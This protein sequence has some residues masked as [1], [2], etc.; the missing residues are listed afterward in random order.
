MKIFIFAIIATILAFVQNSIMF[1]FGFKESAIFSFPLPFVGYFAAEIILFW[2]GAFVIRRFIKSRKE[3][4]FVVWS[5]IVLGIAELM[6]PASLFSTYVKYAQRKSVLNN[7]ELTGKSVEILAAEHKIG[8]RFALKYSLQFPKT[9]HYL[10]F[11]AYI[12]SNDRSRIFGNYFVKI[13]PEYYDENFIFEPGKSYEFTVVFDLGLKQFDA[14]NQNVCVQIYDEKGYFMAGR[15]L[16]VDVGD[17]LKNALASNPAPTAREPAVPADNFFDVAEKSIRLADLNIASPNIK[18]ETP[19]EFAFAI[20]NIGDKDI[21]LPGE[22]F[23]SLAHI[24]Y[25]W[26]ALDESAKKTHAISGIVLFNKNL[27]VAGG[28]LILPK[29]DSLSP[30]DKILVQDKIKFGQTFQ[31]LGPGEY[32]LHV[33]LYNNYSTD[34]NI[35]VQ[36]LT[37]TFLIVP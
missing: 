12:E 30:G 32:K 6:L 26:E 8:S 34:R 5:L 35:P 10:T 24:I 9:G 27:I 33:L 15:T 1:S 3:I 16:K 31:A 29:K 36:D 20:T 13:H 7:I 21:K 28:P 2:T 19:L 11:P 25:A 17:V 4:P 37:A 22:R 14:A 23:D 18:T